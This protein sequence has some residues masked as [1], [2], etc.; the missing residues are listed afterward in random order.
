MRYNP[1]RDLTPCPY[2]EECCMKE[3]G[4]CTALS[5]TS[6]P[7]GQCHF[8]KEDPNG[9]NLYDYPEKRR[10]KIDIRDRLEA[11]GFGNFDWISR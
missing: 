4:D 3:N 8:R 2:T 11:D 7:D 10:E 5:D 6:F 9:Y 1:K